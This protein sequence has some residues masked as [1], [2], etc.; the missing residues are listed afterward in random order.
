MLTKILSG[1]TALIKDGYKED[2]L[3]IL[4]TAT[5]GSPVVPLNASSDTA[6]VDGKEFASDSLSNLPSSTKYV[7]ADGNYDSNELICLVEEKKNEKYITR[8][9][10]TPTGTGKSSS[11]ERKDYKKYLKT[12]KGK[13]VYS[14]RSVTV[15]PLF[16]Q[17]KSLFEMDGCMDERKDECNITSSTLKSIPTNFFCIIMLSKNS[18]WL[19]NLL[20]KS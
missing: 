9:L 4:C 14:R 10:V 13:E 12:K 5:N 8:R 6:N 11:K 16:E 17:I 2:S 15:E 1:D 3:D 7:G 20:T 19:K 18:L